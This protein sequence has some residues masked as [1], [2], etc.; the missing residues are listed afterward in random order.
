MRPARRAPRPWQRSLFQPQRPHLTPTQ[1]PN[2][3]PPEQLRQVRETA[4]RRSKSACRRGCA[5]VVATQDRGSGPFLAT[6]RARQPCSTTR[7]ST[8]KWNIN[9]DLGNLSFLELGLCGIAEITTKECQ[10]FRHSLS[11]CEIPPAA[12]Q[13]PAYCPQKGPRDNVA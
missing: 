3:P 10:Q 11:A 5:A 9:L 1:Q 6:M 2:R 8:L 13:V 12:Q 7:Q 4:H